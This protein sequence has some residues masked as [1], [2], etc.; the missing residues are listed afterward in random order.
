MAKLKA[1]LNSA[2]VS[3]H[4]MV[5][6]G[7]I[8][9]QNGTPQPN[10]MV[11]AFDRNIGAED[12]PL[13][14]ITTDKQ[15]HYAIYYGL[16]KLGGKSAA[17]LV[18][19]VS[20]DGKVL[21]TSDVIFNAKPVE[22]KDFVIP[23]PTNPEFDRFSHVVTPL[24][25]S[26]V[27]LSKTDMTRKISIDQFIKAIEKLPSDRPKE[28]SGKCFKTQKEHWLGW[29]REYG[30]PGAYNRKGGKNRE[31]KSAYNHIIEFKML[32]WIIDA[33]RVDRKL[34]HRAK[35]AVDDNKSM[36]TNSGRI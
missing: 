4:Q 8:I 28:Y 10:L 5:V 6:Q 24:L 9:D 3:E 14:Q 11:R 26:K 36:A 12:T 32:L 31:A 16:E 33:S 20:Q 2:Q 17:D 34:V 22:V 15:G 27:G 23:E 7:K 18:I 21:Q 13:G 19:S 30:G 1:G 25:D 29:L 35:A